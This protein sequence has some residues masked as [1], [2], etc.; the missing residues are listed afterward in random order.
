MHISASGVFSTTALATVLFAQSAVADVSARDVWQHWQDYMAA[1]GYSIEASEAEDG[2]TLSISDMKILMAFPEEEAEAVV[3]FGD[4][5]LMENGDGTVSVVLPENKAVSVSSDTTEESFAITLTLNGDLSTVVSGKPEALTYTY[6]ASEATIDVT[7]LVVDDEAVEGIDIGMVL[8]GV[9]GMSELILGEDT[10]N[11]GTSEI[12]SF[13]LN[14]MAREPEGD[15]ALDAVVT[16]SGLKAQAESTLPDVDF[17]DDAAALFTDT[18]SITGGY[19]YDG[20]TADLTYNDGRAPGKF[21]LSSGKGD[22]TLD[23]NSKHV[24]YEGSA[25]DTNFS[26]AGGELP[27][28][29][30]VTFGEFSYGFDVPLSASD[31]AQ[32]FGLKLALKDFSVSELLWSMFDPT[33]AL[34]RDPATLIVDI[35]GKGTILTDLFTLDENTTEVPGELNTLSLNELRLT[36]AGASVEGAGDFVFDNSDLETFDGLP[37]PE[38]A[39]DL[40]IKGVNGLMDT[41]VSMGLLPEDQA[42]AARFMMGTFTKPGAGEDTLT[43]KIEVNEKGHVMANGQRLR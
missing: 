10:T 8:A 13:T 3:D 42:L 15:E 34:P 9:T 27:I 4:M 33:Q 32:D 40:T 20:M 18:F 12:E 23:M 17:D 41:L 11:R 39:V 22:L 21:A 24:S 1:S 37:R 25:T 6:G 36:L 5:A 14:V 29:V 26:G 35:A 28:P 30:D 7:E 16:L 43:S 31:E 2:N 19:T 38:G